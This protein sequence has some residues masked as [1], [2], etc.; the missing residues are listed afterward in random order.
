MKP[1]TL[2]IYEPYPPEYVDPQRTR[3]LELARPWGVVVDGT[4]Y[5]APAGMRSDGASIPRLLWR[6]VDPPI[7]TLMRRGVILHDA[8]YKGLL[9]AVDAQGSFGIVDDRAEADWL[10]ET[11]GRWNGASA[12][13]AKE[14]YLGVRLFGG[15]PWKVAHKRAEPGAY[16]T[17][18]YGPWP[19]FGPPCQQ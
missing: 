4:M 10:L 18:N 15:R 12:L 6:V 1:A 16:L 8:A 13:T 3:D 11:V 17:M 19:K 7:F 5:I 9:M 14:C 2:S